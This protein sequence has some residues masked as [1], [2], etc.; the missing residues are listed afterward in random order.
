MFPPD[1]PGAIP[2]ARQKLGADDRGSG[3]T[4]G[5]QRSSPVAIGG[6][7]IMEHVRAFVAIELDDA[8]KAALGRIQAQLKRGRMS[9]VARWVSPESIHLTL[10]FLGDV[11]VDRVEDIKQAIQRACI[12]LGPFSIAVSDT[13]CFPTASRPRVIWVG[14]GGDTE[15]L[16][17]LQHSV[18]S[19][20]VGIGFAAERRRF[21]PHLTL[22]R[23][24]R[25]VRSHER[26][27]LGESVSAANADEPASMAVREVSLMRSDLR[28]T[29]AVYTRLA[30]IPLRE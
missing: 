12:S 24:K 2:T 18:E 16:A 3:G 8:L 5:G 17:R 6:A 27:Q 14:I 13:G 19:E 4:A 20:L 23:T 1:R 29:G 10:K 28:P 22:A 11:P 25:N 26:A 21:H 9:H 30:A 7:L 15:E